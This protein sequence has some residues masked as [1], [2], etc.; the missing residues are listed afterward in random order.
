MTSTPRST[1]IHRILNVRPGTPRRADLDPPL[2]APSLITRDRVSA[3][4]HQRGYSSHFDDDGDITGTWDGNRFW[5]LL[6]GPGEEILQI[7][8]RWHRTL[9]Q[10]GRIST[11]QTINDWN[12]ERIWPKAYVRAEASGLSLY[13]EVSVDFSPGA[14]DD[15]LHQ[16]VAC[17]LGTAVQLFASVSAMLPPEA[18]EDPDDDVDEADE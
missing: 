14:T 2:E 6:L 11:L 15:Q 3:Y 10:T 9:P 18:K 7:R 17:G 16:M 5:F 4:L 12:R 8:G 1:W 13:T